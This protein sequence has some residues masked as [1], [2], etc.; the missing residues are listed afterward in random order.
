MLHS[1]KRKPKFPPVCNTKQMFVNYYS[2]GYQATQVEQKPVS[3][4]DI[5]SCSWLIALKLDK[6]TR[7]RA[8]VIKMGMVHVGICV[9]VSSHLKDA[10]A[11][12]KMASGY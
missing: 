7:R 10:W 8:S 9:S 12:D 4:W 1:N 11:A 5:I 2:K 3:P 6:I